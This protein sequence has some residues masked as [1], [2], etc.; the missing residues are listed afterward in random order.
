MT[1]KNISNEVEL[2]EEFATI[3]LLIPSK[4]E[5][6]RTDA[7]VLAYTKLDKQIRRIFTNLVYRSGVSPEDVSSIIVKA[8]LYPD[9][10]IRG[11]DKLCK[12]SFA[13]IIGEDYQKLN[14][15]WNNLREDRNKILH[16]QVT[17]KN[18]GPEDLKKLVKSI[19]KWMLLIAERM[20]D[21]IG[22]N[23]LGKSFKGFVSSKDFSGIFAHN[24]NDRDEL[25][26]FIIEI[27]GDNIKKRNTKI[28]KG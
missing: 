18:Y 2:N 20:S 5:T 24:I 19:R 4:T 6:G 17:G 28:L 27:S 7:F 13:D 10:F 9:D 25:I 26:E 11:I 21:K 15:D 23:G 3:D 12:I 16:G 8:I 1:D 22:Y 14:E